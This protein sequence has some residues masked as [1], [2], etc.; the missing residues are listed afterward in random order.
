MNDV[1]KL[2]LHYVIAKIKTI[3]RTQYDNKVYEN[4]LAIFNQ[5]STREKR[6]LLK[7]LIN[8]C[9]LMED[10]FNSINTQI[11]QSPEVDRKIRNESEVDDIESYNKKELVNLKTWLA[12]AGF[13]SMSLFFTFVIVVVII[14][15][16]S[17]N[18]VI[19]S[20]GHIGEVLKAVFGS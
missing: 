5:L 17:D 15:S 12:K 19:K 18:F 14:F 6:I 13:V 11:V 4:I 16:S 1:E 7:G 8:T 20:L 2:T 3:G 9:F 10:A